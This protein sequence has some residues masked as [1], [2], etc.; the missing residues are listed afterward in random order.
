MDGLF[1]NQTISRDCSLTVL[2][3]HSDGK[4]MAN[5]KL[6]KMWKETVVA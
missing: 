6:E 3:D 4:V 5:D 2:F 1:A